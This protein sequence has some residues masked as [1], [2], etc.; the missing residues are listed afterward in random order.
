MATKET[1]KNVIT[2]LLE[3]YDYKELTPLAQSMY[4]SL[5]GTIPDDVLVQAAQNHMAESNFFPKPAELV[6]QAKKIGVMV[7]KTPDN[8]VRYDTYGQWIESLERQELIKYAAKSFADDNKCY[9]YLRNLTIDPKHE[10]G[11]DD[12]PAWETPPDIDIYDQ[13]IEDEFLR[14]LK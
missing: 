6:A 8:F 12:E 14:G 9:E 1:V 2:A 7:Y 4:Q 10:I 5:L 3:L 13:D 11:N